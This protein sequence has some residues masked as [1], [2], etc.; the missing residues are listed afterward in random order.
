LTAL[1][2]LALAQ[3]ADAAPTLVVK[4]PPA[5]MTAAQFQQKLTPILE[6]RKLQQATLDQQT[7]TKVQSAL[8]SVEPERKLLSAALARD[9]RYQSLLDQ[10]RAISTS[11]ADAATRAAQMQALLGANRVV[12][13][14][15]LRSSGVDPAA[16]QSKLQ[17][18][19]A[20]VRKSSPLSSAATPAT[21]PDLKL[22]PPLDFES[23]ET[24][25]GGLAYSAAVA[26]A[27]VDAGT[28]KMHATV[29][30]VAGSAKGDSIVGQSIDVPAGVSRIEVTV[31]ASISYNGA[32]FSAL[33][34][35]TACANVSIELWTADLSDRLDAD[36]IGDCVMAPIGWYEEMSGDETRD[37][38]YS[39]SV[40]GG[41][42]HF[43]LFGD[44]HSFTIGGGIPGYGEAKTR[45][46]IKKI[47]VHF[48]QN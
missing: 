47:K 30:G 39:T 29:I 43:V 37:Y 7:S 15:A 18:K 45:A 44:A 28:A 22:S 35:S 12:F 1:G 25:N 10:A 6:A 24:N 46:E 36:A 34:A 16:F 13:N 40:T 5:G 38:V 31:T 17:L 3:G 42:R 33:L 9:P 14:D 19:L 48:V 4:R 27:D 11:K 32:A 2:V 21:I 26:D 8:A 41:T 23:T 20:P